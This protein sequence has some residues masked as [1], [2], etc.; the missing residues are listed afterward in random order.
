MVLFKIDVQI[1]E[2]GSAEIKSGLKNLQKT[3]DRTR[4]IVSGI[5]KRIKTDKVRRFNRE[6]RKTGD[7]GK[8]VRGIITQIFG[9]IGVGL[10]IREIVRMSDVYQNFQNRLK[11]VTT[12]TEDLTAVTKQLFEVANDT[13]VSFAATAELFTRVSIATKNLG[14]TQKEVIAFT[15]TLNKAV[16]LS[17]ATAAEAK[18]GII[19]LSQGLASGA[20]RG[21][22]LRSVLEQL[23]KVADAI[24]KSMGIT[25]GELRKMGEAGKISADIIIDAMAKAAAGID[26][27]FGTT[28]PTISQAFTVLANHVT[29]MVGEFNKASGSAEF[30]ARRL[31]DVGENIVLITEILGALALGFIAVKVQARLAGI[32]VLGFAKKAKLAIIGINPLVAGFGILAVVA[33]ELTNAITSSTSA[34]DELEAKVDKMTALQKM[35]ANFERMNFRL[36]A[37][38]VEVKKGLKLSAS[39]EK[40]FLKLDLSVFNL[41]QKIKGLKDG[42]TAATNAQKKLTRAFEASEKSLER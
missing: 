25:R 12:S 38:G 8:Q 18:N 35:E 10:A 7:I 16:I 36:Q 9:A 2:K 22:E 1:R 4:K 33:A 27:D 31:V 19:Q 32:S 11:I 5:G 28:I 23:P 3:A 34:L 14:R 37:W 13:P 15:R 39:Q 40:A 42:S 20:L 26:K 30:F 24:S 6:L 29:Q 41:N 17:G 21:D